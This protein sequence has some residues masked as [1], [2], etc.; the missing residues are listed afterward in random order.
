MFLPWIKPIRLHFA[1]LRPHISITPR[2]VV[3][4]QTIS[5]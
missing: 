2:D 1:H 3:V 4:G 5:V